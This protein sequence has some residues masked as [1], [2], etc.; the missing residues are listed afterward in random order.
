MGVVW[1]WGS[2]VGPGSY[3]GTIASA[4]SGVRGELSNPSPIIVVGPPSSV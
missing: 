4:L 1:A 2:A 3:I